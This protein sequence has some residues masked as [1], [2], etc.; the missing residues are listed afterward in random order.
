[1]RTDV[2]NSHDIS[3]RSSITNGKFAASWRSRRYSND[4]VANDNETTTDSNVIDA[5]GNVN[6]C[7][8]NGQ[9]SYVKRSPFTDNKYSLRGNGLRKAP[10]YF[11][12][13]GNKSDFHDIYEN[14]TKLSQYR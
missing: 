9:H 11:Q 10:P 12:D 2:V 4:D 14:S 6:G 5:N 7:T 8:E 13:N 3:N 1:M